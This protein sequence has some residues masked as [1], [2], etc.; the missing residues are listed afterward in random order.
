[1]CVNVHFF[2]HTKALCANVKA[3]YVTEFSF[4]TNKCNKSKRE[5]TRNAKALSV[6]VR[7]FYVNVKAFR[8][9]ST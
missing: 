4:N 8:N 2:L 6:Q 5:I 1:M 9:N 7:A 3:F